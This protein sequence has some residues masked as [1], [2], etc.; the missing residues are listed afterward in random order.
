MV[1][2]ITGYR[3]F[4]VVPG[5][6][7]LND[8]RIGILGHRGMSTDFIFPGNSAP[9]ILKALNLGAN[10]CEV[11]VQ[12]TKDG[13]LIAYHHKYLDGYT[14]SVGMIG[15]H[16]YDALKTVQ[17]TGDFAEET[18]LIS[19]DSLFTIIEK[20]ENYIFSLDCKLLGLEAMGVHDFFGRFSS[21]LERLI[22]KHGMEN[23][24]FIESDN[25][26]FHRFLKTQKIPVKQFI[27]GK[28]ISNGI[29]IATDLK[30]FGI[31]VGSSASSRDIKT[32]HEN[33][34]RV[35][36]WTP[37]NAFENIRAV[38]KNPDFIQTADLDHLLKFLEKDQ[39]QK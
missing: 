2:L 23:R 38:R 37:R 8:N 18:S 35:M 15:E 39:A 24:I 25:I 32:A 12:L 27:T 30:L 3:Y 13:K 31:G 10:G 29:Q 11:D 22:K 34:L 9:S 28:G 33:G 20:P 6:S 7:N 14:T 17:Y 36:T 1:L 16:T 5:I 4:S 26:E 21:E 19:I